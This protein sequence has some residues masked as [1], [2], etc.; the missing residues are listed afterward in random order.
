MFGVHNS[1][2]DEA[3][4]IF[5]LVEA[6]MYAKPAAVWPRTDGH[7]AICL[8]EQACT[9]AWAKGRDDMLMP[10]RTWPCRSCLLS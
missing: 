3:P 1:S 4:A 5:L 8:A 10:H 6:H 2:V 9:A 7:L